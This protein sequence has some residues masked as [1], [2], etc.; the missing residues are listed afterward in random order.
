MSIFESPLLPLEVG[1]EVSVIPLRLSFGQYHNG[2][3]KVMR[4]QVERLANDETFFGIIG[5]AMFFDRR[6]EGV[7]WCRSN[8][9]VAVAALLAAAA[10]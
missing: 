8:D 10:L 9:D 5:S 3:P 7:S 4:T 1:E 6:E 2:L